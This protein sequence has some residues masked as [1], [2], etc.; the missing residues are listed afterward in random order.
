[1]NEVKFTRQELYDLVWSQPMSVINKTYKNTDGGVRQICRKLD[2]PLPNAGYWALAQ[3]GKTVTRRPLGDFAGDQTVVIKLRDGIE[4]NEEN[5]E[6]VNQM[7]HSAFLKE[8]ESDKRLNLIVPERLTNPDKLIV[9]VKDE[10]QKEDTRDMYEGLIYSSGNE[11]DIRVSPKNIGRALRFMDTLIK[12]LRTRGHEIK[13]KGGNTYVSIFEEDYVIWLRERLKK[14]KIQRERWDYTEKRPS[15]TLT[16]RINEYHYYSK[17][18]ADGKHPLESRLPSILASLELMAKKRHDEQ[19][20]W[21][22][23]R[24]EQKEKERI[25]KEI[26]DRKEEELMNFKEIFKNAIRHDKAEIIRKYA[27]E[28]KKFAIARN[29]MTDELKAE[30]AWIMKKADW[31]DP[32]IEADDEFLD[33]VDRESLTFIFKKTRQW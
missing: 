19:I 4:L 27:A 6:I 30:I 20:R 31:Y 7:T 1:M 24:Q 15:G 13:I 21:E 5:K 12:A 25:A 16:F 32:F 22:I 33:D 17:E 26:Q 9:S 29:E 2:V 23:Q 10:L 14:V 28:M 11:L 18:W 3:Y 8:I